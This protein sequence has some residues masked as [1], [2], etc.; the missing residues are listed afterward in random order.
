MTLDIKENDSN[1]FIIDKSEIS[2]RI[3]FFLKC[4]P[5]LILCKF[6]HFFFNGYS[7]SLLLAVRFIRTEIKFT[8]AKI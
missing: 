4:T 5:K 3:L 8:A 7:V 1:S 2:I 6:Y